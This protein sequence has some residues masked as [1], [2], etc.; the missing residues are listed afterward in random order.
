MMNI[1]FHPLEDITQI[2][3]FFNYEIGLVVRPDSPWKTWEELKT[4]AKQNPGKVRYGSPGVGSMQQLTFEM[5]GQKEGIKWIHIPFR[6]SRET[7]TAV[8]GGHIEATIPGKPD[9]V[10]LIKNGQLRFLLPLNDK[11]WEVAPNVPHLGELGYDNAFTYFS[12]WGP[13]G[14][15]EAVRSKLE[16]VF[17]ESMNDQNY[18][19]AASNS[20]VDVVFVGGKKYTEMLK[21][22]YPKYKK[23]VEDLGLKE[24]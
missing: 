17:H 7:V 13:K 11:R 21:E 12:L 22:K 18:V 15:P 8:L 6:G 1:P 23:A 3:V 14:I 5:I 2:L 9:V 16:N 10:P 20:N 19:K 24:K 4:Y